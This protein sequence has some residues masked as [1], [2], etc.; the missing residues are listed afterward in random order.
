MS[1]LVYASGRP[2]PQLLKSVLDQLDPA[3]ENADLGLVFLADPVT[4]MADVML[5]G[6]RARTGIQVWLGAASSAVFAGGRELAGE[7]AIAALPLRLGETTLVPFTGRLPVGAASAASGIV[8]VPDAADAPGAFAS[9]VGSDDC[10]LVGGQSASAFD[11]ALITLSPSAGAATGVL[12]DGAARLVSG[13]SHGCRPLGPTHRVTAARGATILSLDGMPAAEVLAGE[14]GELLL[15]EQRLLSRQLLAACLSSDQASPATQ[16]GLP[17]LFGIARANRIEGSIE[18]LGLPAGSSPPGRIAFHH[19]D[20]RLALHELESLAT[21]L[22]G[23][24]D[25]RPPRAAL[26]YSSTERG[27]RFF[28]PGV[29]EA[30]ILAAQLG[31]VPLIGMRSNAE[32]AAGGLT[33]YSTVLALIG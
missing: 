6:L 13:V 1:G 26:L 30:T 28:G 23:A 17:M 4:E 16:A 14:A 5:D 21:R 11:H 2:W 32:I 22:L 31:P 3:P 12:L 10:R 27:R 20:P 8:H 19:R 18:L 15:H 9:L 29:D 24:L 33:R 25:G 7:G